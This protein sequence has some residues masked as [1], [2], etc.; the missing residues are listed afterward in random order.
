[1]KDVI[2]HHLDDLISEN[3]H[4][5][6]SATRITLSPDAF[7]A[8]LKAMRQ[9]ELLADPAATLPDTYKGVALEVRELPGTRFIELL[10][11]RGDTVFRDE[12]E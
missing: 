12:E 3:E 6:H 7:V 8:L 2:V 1:M 4:A 5:G 11:E 9:D 10:T